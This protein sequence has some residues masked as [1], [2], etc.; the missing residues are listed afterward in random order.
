MYVVTRNSTIKYSRVQFNSKQDNAVVIDIDLLPKLVWADDQARDR[1][2]TA[3]VYEGP[4]NTVTANRSTHPTNSLFNKNSNYVR[5]TLT[6]QPSCF[7]VEIP[8]YRSMPQSKFSNV[9]MLCSV[10]K[11]KNFGVLH[12]GRFHWIVSYLFSRGGLDFQ[13][14]N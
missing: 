6:K 11:S 2:S 10:A 5:N 1:I 3:L 9:L 14:S 4:T 13:K 7:P 8:W 12:L